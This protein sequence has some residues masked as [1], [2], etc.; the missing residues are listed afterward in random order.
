[1]ACLSLGGWLPELS[2]SRTLLQRILHASRV[3][4]AVRGVLCSCHPAPC[5]CHSTAWL[6]GWR[7]LLPFLRAEY[8]RQHCCA[9]HGG[10]LA[11]FV[12]VKKVPGE[13][14]PQPSLRKLSPGICSPRA[15]ELSS[16]ICSSVRACTRIGDSVNLHHPL[17]ISGIL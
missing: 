9:P 16:Q 14:I 7:L 17:Y 12:G 3:C 8:W 10:L 1:M 15:P 11:A 6:A 2:P 13:P 4:P 5:D